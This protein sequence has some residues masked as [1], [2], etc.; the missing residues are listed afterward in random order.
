MILHFY[1]NMYYM[2]NAFSS[3]ALIFCQKQFYTILILLN[4]GFNALIIVFHMFFAH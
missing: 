4:N 1:Y 2:Y 3:F